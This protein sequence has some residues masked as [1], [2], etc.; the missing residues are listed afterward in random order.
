M[1]FS[2]FLQVIITNV[3]F[4]GTTAN[5]AVWNMMIFEIQRGAAYAQSASAPR[6]RPNRQTASEVE[7]VQH[8]WL[9]RYP[10]PPDPS[11]QKHSKQTRRPASFHKSYSGCSF[12][13][14][15]VIKEH[16]QDDNKWNADVHLYNTIFQ[17]LDTHYNISP[18]CRLHSI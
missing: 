17:S 11:G 4:S 16:I 10:P 13:A 9:A 1:F 15:S 5:T 18:T 14:L 6:E 8:L 3:N 7:E 12:C 2:E